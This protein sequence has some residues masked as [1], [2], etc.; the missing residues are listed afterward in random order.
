MK[1][2]LNHIPARHDAINIRLEELALLDA[3]K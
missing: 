3:L 1:I 2:D